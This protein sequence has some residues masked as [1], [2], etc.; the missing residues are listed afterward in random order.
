MTTTTSGLCRWLEIRKA[1]GGIKEDR[2]SALSGWTL[3]AKRSTNLWIFMDWIGLDAS[4]L[5]I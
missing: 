5:L 3:G 4:K 1:V 2:Y